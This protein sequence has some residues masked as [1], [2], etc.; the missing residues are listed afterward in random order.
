MSFLVAI[1][2]F[3]GIAISSVAFPRG[4]LIDVFAF[5][6]LGSCC[7]NSGFFSLNFAARAV[8]LKVSI[9]EEFSFRDS[10]SR[11]NS[12]SDPHTP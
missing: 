2:F 3:S 8:S 10:L 4:S 9:F 11:F 6:L 1:E 5:L 12:H 7:C